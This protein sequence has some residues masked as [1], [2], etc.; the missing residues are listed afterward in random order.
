MTDPFPSF[1][2][3]FS[4]YWLGL[5]LLS[6]RSNLSTAV[7]GPTSSTNSQFLELA[8]FPGIQVTRWVIRGGSGF[9]FTAEQ[10]KQVYQD[11]TQC[12]EL[13]FKP[14]HILSSELQIRGR[15]CGGK[16]STYFLMYLLVHTPVSPYF[17]CAYGSSFFTY[18]SLC[19][20][21]V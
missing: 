12:S 11:R 20:F 14:S 1:C 7:P 18:F 19:T 17:R 3:A 9:W 21:I 13:K 10:W 16:L 8:G 2:S 15:D 4:T 6:S 5:S